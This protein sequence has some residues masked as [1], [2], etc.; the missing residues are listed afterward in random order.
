MPDE[1]PETEIPASAP[2]QTENQT[3]PAPVQAAPPAA[4]IV[5]KGEVADERALALERRERAA[6]EREQRLRDEEMRIAE[7][8]KK[9]QEREAALIA[10]T[11]PKQ[12]R[13]Y[14]WS[15]PVFNDEDGN[16]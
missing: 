16:E 4:E 15:D 8:E 9:T 10:P 12:K 1:I 7:R 5:V 3:P 14:G 13:K 11:K 6:A 2:V